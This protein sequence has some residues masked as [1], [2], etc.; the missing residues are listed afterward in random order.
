MPRY[1]PRTLYSE[2][3]P[4]CCDWLSNLMDAG[5]I[6]PGHIDDRTIE[7]ITPNDLRG[8]DHAH[9]FAGIGGW[10]RAFELADYHQ[11][12]TWTGSCPC[13]PFSRAGQRAG[14][15]DS[16][17]LWPA[18][19]RL[20]RECRPQRVFGEQVASAIGHGWLDDVSTDLEGEGYAVGAVVLGAH[21]AGAPHM[22][23][24]L[25]WV[26]HANG[27]RREQQIERKSYQESDIAEKSVVRASSGVG[28]ANGERPQGR[29]L[30][31]E[32]HTHQS[33]AWSS[34]VAVE[35]D[36]GKT[37]FIE[38]GIRPVANGVPERVGRLRALGNAI[39]PQVAAQFIDAVTGG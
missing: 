27:E 18:W 12:S 5:H 35:C 31:P 33:S 36:D 25:W 20:I 38:P 23:Q 7:D 34:S 21:S 29:R 3:D 10:A 14:T 2:I 19:F 4:Y 1:S 13:Q 37:R 30:N 6:S 8:Y 24:R 17:H 11:P 15:D 26:G 32:K 39:V 28:N 9:F 22:R 16:R